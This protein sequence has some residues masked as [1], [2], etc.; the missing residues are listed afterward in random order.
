MA[1]H[2][3][4]VADALFVLQNGLI[5][6]ERK[7]PQR[8]LAVEGAAGLASPR[9]LWNNRPGENALNRLQL[10]RRRLAKLPRQPGQTGM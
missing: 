4:D 2:F 7:T 6:V 8:T 9:A 5:I 1:Q 3:G 10:L